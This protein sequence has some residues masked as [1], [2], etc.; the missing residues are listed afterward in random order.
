MYTKVMNETISG[1]KGN[2]ITLE[3]AEARAALSVREF[4][5]LM[6]CAPISIYRRI[7][8]GS[9]QTISIGSRKLIPHGFYMKLIEEG[10]RI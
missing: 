2:P 7:E 3:E 9:I 10:G 1:Q 4:A 5:Q 6:G 8:S